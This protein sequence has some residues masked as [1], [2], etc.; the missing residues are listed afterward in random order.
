MPS[1]WARYHT[2]P[3]HTIPCHTCGFN[4]HRNHSALSSQYI[5]GFG[6]TRSAKEYII[7][8]IYHTSRISHKS[9]T[10]CCKTIHLFLTRKFHSMSGY[11]PVQYPYVCFTGS[12]ARNAPQVERGAHLMFHPRGPNLRRSWMTA[13]KKDSEKRSFF[14][15]PGLVHESKPSSVM[16]L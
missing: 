4:I 12:M 5:V 14:Q 2:I 13:W 16:S 1:G 11:T 10:H 8:G 7:L 3:Y 9:L 6:P 15:G